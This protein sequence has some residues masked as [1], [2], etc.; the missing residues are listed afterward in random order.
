MPTHSAAAIIAIFAEEGIDCEP[1]E[2][3]LALYATDPKAYAQAL[4]ACCTTRLRVVTMGPDQ[5]APPP[6]TND[7]MI[8]G[9]PTHDADRVVAIKR[10]PSRTRQPWEP[11]AARRAA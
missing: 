6:C 5:P 8:C 11:R 2:L 9:C 3:G 1:H 4:K 7:P 10:G